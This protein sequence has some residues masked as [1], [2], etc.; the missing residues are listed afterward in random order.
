MRPD[1]WWLN[2][3]FSFYV[4]PAK[5]G[6]HN[7]NRPLLR[8]AKKGNGHRLSHAGH[9]VWVVSLGYLDRL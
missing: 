1:E 7:H 5:A 9:G 4:V 3:A 2:F 8:T 6:T